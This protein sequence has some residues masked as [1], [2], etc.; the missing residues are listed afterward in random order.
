MF[1]I[2]IAIASSFNEAENNILTIHEC[3]EIDVIIIY[4]WVILMNNKIMQQI[5]SPLITQKPN[6]R[7]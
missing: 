5:R 1:P 6:N 2:F 4:N 7:Y 3:I